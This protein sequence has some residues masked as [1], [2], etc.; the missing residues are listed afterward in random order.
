VSYYADGD[1]EDQPDR[2]ELLAQLLERGMHP[3]LTKAQAHGAAKK[4]RDSAVSLRA[5]LDDGRMPIAKVELFRRI[6]T[7]TGRAAQFELA[8]LKRSL[9]ND[10]FSEA[11]IHG[12]IPDRSP[13]APK[14]A[15]PKEGEQPPGEPK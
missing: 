15:A 4:A 14:K 2:M 13:P 9:K 5:V 6:R 12:V 10:G 3:K 11:E 7:A 8:S 1:T